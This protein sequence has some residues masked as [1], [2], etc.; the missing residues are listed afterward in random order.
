[1]TLTNDIYLLLQIDMYGSVT[2]IAATTVHWYIYTL[3]LTIDLFLIE[4]L[5][6][7]PSTSSPATVAVHD[8]L[9]W[10]V[11]RQM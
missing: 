8:E 1:M 5:A 4:V 9:V 10:D 3:F 6:V 7:V 2:A 11:G